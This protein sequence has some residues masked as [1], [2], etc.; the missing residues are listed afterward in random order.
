MA[1]LKRHIILV[2]SQKIFCSFS[3]WWEM[4]VPNIL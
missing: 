1:K 2:S 3:S 4:L